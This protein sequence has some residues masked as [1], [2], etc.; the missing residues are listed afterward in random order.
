MKATRGNVGKRDAYALA[1]EMIDE[2]IEA[3]CPLQAIAIEESV[4]SDRL[5]STLNVG[6]DRVSDSDLKKQGLGSALIQLKNAV[7]G[8]EN[9][10]RL[11][12]DELKCQ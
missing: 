6:R 1:F 7:D 9:S 5:W 12:D 11:F 3:H 8:K 2:A 4:L 10:C